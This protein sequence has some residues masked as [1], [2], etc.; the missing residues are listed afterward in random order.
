M[1]GWNKAGGLL[2]DQKVR[3]RTTANKG[4]ARIN[5]KGRPNSFD[6]IRA[7]FQAVSHEQVKGKNGNTLLVIESIAR[8]WASSPEPVLQKA[9]VEYAYGKVPNKLETTGADGAP[10]K[11]MVIE[12]M[13]PQPLILRHAHE[14]PWRNADGRLRA[15]PAILGKLK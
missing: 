10:H 4:D 12:V 5:R 2:A 9:F 13:R 14:L 3:Q 7:I 6:A 8:Q 11:P 1:G 15:G